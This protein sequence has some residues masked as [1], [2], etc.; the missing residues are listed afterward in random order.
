VVISGNRREAT[1]YTGN[2]RAAGAARWLYPVTDG[3]KPVTGHKQVTPWGKE[4]GKI[5]LPKGNVGSTYTNAKD[6]FF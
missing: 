4:K 1:G 5:L 2:D 6:N 3:L